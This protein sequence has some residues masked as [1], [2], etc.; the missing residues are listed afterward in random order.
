MTKS[1]ASVVNNVAHCW[2]KVV[3]VLIW[4]PNCQRRLSG[5]RTLLWCNCILCRQVSPKLF[6]HFIGS[7]DSRIISMPG[8]SMSVN[9][10]KCLLCVCNDS[11]YTQ[12]PIRVSRC[13]IRRISMAW[14][15]WGVNS[16]KYLT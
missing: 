16:I 1:A 7:V 6:F 12:G 14:L 10:S 2:I 9:A 4:T 3:R 11:T 5:C 15:V 13:S 8:L